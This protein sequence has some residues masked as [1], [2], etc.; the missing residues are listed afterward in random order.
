MNDIDQPPV[1]RP[2]RRKRKGRVDPATVV[3]AGSVFELDPTDDAFTELARKH[4]EWEPRA[5]T[6]ISRH[7]RPGDTFVDVGA[8]IG[9]YTVLASNLVG[10]RGRVVAFEPEPRNFALLRR[11]VELNKCDNVVLEQRAVSVRSGPAD[12]YLAEKNKG[13]HRLFSFGERR[14]SIQIE[15]VS[16]D[17]YLAEHPGSVQHVKIDTQ[18]GEGSV[19]AGMTQTLWREPH[20]TLY[21]E[22]WPYALAGSGYEPYWLLANL[23]R[24]G[25]DLRDI[26][27]REP[28]N[29]STT[30]AKLLGR[31]TVENRR[32]T[33]LFL[34]CSERKAG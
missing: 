24:H 31:Y 3:L 32:F 12:L 17:D 6:V 8:H 30:I 22:F 25:F 33:E 14:R 28:R 19:L 10:P 27:H 16:L 34:C 2:I 15:T 9:Y 23:V 11:N 4:N 21:I 1:Y 29:V 13:D 7:V 18:G 5:T 26:N 20:L